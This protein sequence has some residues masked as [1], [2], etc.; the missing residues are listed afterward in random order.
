MARRVGRWEG[1]GVA[2]FFAEVLAQRRHD[3]RVEAREKIG[4]HRGRAG[5]FTQKHVASVVGVTASTISAWE[6]GKR[7]RLVRPQH[8]WALA[9]VYGLSSNEMLE[10]AGYLPS[11]RFLRRES[12]R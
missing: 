7:L 1:E 11:P 2:P 5:M 10:A 4:R 12:R 9:E 8:F 6:R 3:L